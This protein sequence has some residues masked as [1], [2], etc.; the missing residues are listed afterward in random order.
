MRCLERLIARFQPA[1]MP[2]VPPNARRFV[3]SNLDLP[4]LCRHRFTTD[5]GSISSDASGRIDC[6]MVLAGRYFGLS[7]CNPRT[8]PRT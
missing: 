5:Y 3:M 1:M 8:I 4:V 2:F 7:T 6:T